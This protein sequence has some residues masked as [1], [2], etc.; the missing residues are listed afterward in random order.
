MITVSDL[1]LRAGPR[2]LLDDATFRVGPGDKVGLVGRNGAGKT[3]LTRVLAGDVE[4][5]PEY[6]AEL[7]IDRDEIEDGFRLLCS[8]FAQTEFQAAQFMPLVVT[9][10]LLLCGLLQPRQTLVTP[11]R[12]ASNVMPLSYAT[13]A[14]TE[15]TRVAGL[16]GA[17]A[18]DLAVLV[19]CLVVFMALSAVSIRRTTA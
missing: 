9:P 3:T 12:W 14:F 5:D 11:L 1:E 8:A 6:A 10:Q 15:A 7:N 2:L 4:H 19:G 17:M 16:N 18:R 13:D